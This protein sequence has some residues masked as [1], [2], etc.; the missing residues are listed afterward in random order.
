MY[1]EILEKIKE[2]RT[3]II[4]RHSRPDGD[5]MGSQIGLKEAI[6]ATF[7]EK[8]VLAVGDVNERYSFIGGMDVVVDEDYQEALVFILDTSDEFMISDDRYNLGKFIIKIDHHILK[9]DFGHMQIIDTSFESCAGLIA[10]I[11]FST[12]MKL[13]NIG[14]KAIF[15]GIVTD[16]GRFRYDSV[17]SRTFDLASKLLQYDFSMNEIYNNLY[18]EELKMVKL[19]AQFTLNFKITKKNVA[20]TKT[21]ARDLKEFDT[22]LFTISRGMV[23]TMSGIKGIDI[24][25]N[26]TE[27]EINNTVIAEIR[28][29]KYNINEIAV[30]YG[31]G[32]HQMASGATL[33]SFEEADLMLNDLENLIED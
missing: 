5:A 14:A 22:D 13:T 30:K 21:T 28:S 18:S 4:H 2:Y 9:K 25:V 29:S 19:R 31:G 8:K 16:S 33:K 7:P 32:G 1:T 20:Y 17:N 11:I 6:Q 27:D 12:N 3:I 26:F 23:N 15:T 24:W 10:H